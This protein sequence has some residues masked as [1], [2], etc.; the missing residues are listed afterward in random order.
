MKETGMPLWYW[1]LYYMNRNLGPNISVIIVNIY[2]VIM[3]LSL[4]FQRTCSFN[5][6]LLHT[7]NYLRWCVCNFIKLSTIIF[8]RCI[9]CQIHLE[10]GYL[11]LYYFETKRARVCETFGGGERRDRNAHLNSLI[12]DLEKIWN[13]KYFIEKLYL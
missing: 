1:T 9:T 8:F 3:C 2:L 12:P 10:L 13:I 4:L 5:T 7:L 11:C 6:Y